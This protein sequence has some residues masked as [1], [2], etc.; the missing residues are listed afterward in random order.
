[1]KIKVILLLATSMILLSATA[2]AF[3]VYK[4]RKVMPNYS[5]NNRSG[6]YYG[7]Q[8]GVSLLHMSP[9][10][11][12]KTLGFDLDGFMGY[13]FNPNFRADI[14]V[15]WLRNGYKYPNE[16]PSRVLST[17]M[18]QTYVLYNG[19]YDFSVAKG[20]TPYLGL[21][22]GYSH[23]FISGSL[24]G[25][26][27]VDTLG[28]NGF[29]FTATAGINSVLIPD[30]FVFGMG[31]RLIGGLYSVDGTSSTILNSVISFSLTYTL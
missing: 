4:I 10:I 29:G 26:H 5:T 6:L 21:G 12:F 24:V 7:G 18:D 27:V 23:T 11:G 1:M 17:Y 28:T 14:S 3:P 20:L 30:V 25:V 13:Q 2:S 19:Y 9:D 16:D 22:V 15:D 31:Y 8:G